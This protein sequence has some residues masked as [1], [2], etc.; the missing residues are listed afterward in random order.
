VGNRLFI[1]RGVVVALSSALLLLTFLAADSGRAWWSRR[2]N[3]SSNQ[4]DQRQRQQ[5]ESAARRPRQNS[6]FPG[7]PTD[8]IDVWPDHRPQA[9]LLT[10]AV[11]Q[12]H[13]VEPGGATTT[14]KNDC[15]TKK[16][17][18]EIHIELV[19][20]PGVFGR[21]FDDFVEDFIRTLGKDAGRMKIR[22]TSTV[23]PRAESNPLSHDEEKPRGTRLMIRL[24]ILPVALEAF[25]LAL[26]LNHQQHDIVDDDLAEFS[27]LWAA[28][29]CH[30]SRLAAGD[31]ENQEQR[32]PDIPLLTIPLDLLLAYPMKTEKQMAE[33][34]G[35][36]L[37]PEDKRK[38]VVMEP[39]IARAL[40]RI[41]ACYNI[42]LAQRPLLNRLPTIPTN[43]SEALSSMPTGRSRATA[44]PPWLA[45][46]RRILS[47]GESMASICATE[48]GWR[49]EICETNT[50]AQQ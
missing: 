13:C 12:N 3:P 46:V 18:Q 47:D 23:V 37:P 21:L 40:A 20:S 27:K 2:T 32:Y 41:D 11:L 50:S 39:R 16:H 42:S 15:A 17:D 5:Q 44:S 7:F 6:M 26:G 38:H 14:T 30:V 43:C 34:M 49:L 48:H 36:S 19:R 10:S 29:H 1:R 33:F 45:L 31:G 25:D 35:I 28:W 8:F 24:A 4:E 22:I 9:K